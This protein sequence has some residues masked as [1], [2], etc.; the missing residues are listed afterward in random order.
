MSEENTAQTILQVIPDLD[1][2]GAERT[3]I[4]IAKALVARG[5]RALV[6]ATGG[7]LVD[8]LE[9]H[10]GVFIPMDVASKNPVRI[11]LNA[12]KLAKLIRAH[13]V[14][15]IH[16]R[17][18]APAWSAF[19]AARMTSATYMTTYHG[20]YTQKSA[21]KGWY[22]SVMARGDVVIA[23]SR[24]TADLIAERHGPVLKDDALHVVYRGTIM[25]DFD[26]G[27]VSQARLDDL[28]QQWRLKPDVP[29]I[30]QMGR[31]TE[32]KGQR[33]VI[34]AARLLEGRGGLPAQ[35]II[36][37]SEQGRT[38]YRQALEEA[39]EKGGLHGKVSLVGHC[40]DVPAAMALADCA[41]IASTEPEAF[42]RAAVEAQA[43]ACP[44]IVSDLG[45][46]PETVLAPPRVADAA[47]TGWHVPANDAPALA[48]AIAEVLQLPVDV[49]QTLGARAR[50][51]VRTQFS[52][53][54]MCRRTLA[55]YDRLL[56]R[57]KT[58]L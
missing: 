21:L 22:N 10:G 41:I 29:V 54:Q 47:R 42:G 6:V 39:I 46:V 12:L 9:A 31:L 57:A 23:N 38:A 7:I 14:D 33:V 35:I 1:T 5:D 11:L 45:A 16:A 56:T 53:E 58:G 25:T 8:E 17:S 48:D 34:E 4:D 26:T 52:L 43:A 30:V 50:Q 49:R 3:T 51:H 19:L 28:R 2:G 44:V 18:R 36:A 20:A 27:A 24:Y 55:L 37:G 32:W 13:K 40:A 15:I